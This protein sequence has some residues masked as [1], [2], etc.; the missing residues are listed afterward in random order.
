VGIEIGPGWGWAA[1]ILSEIEEDALALQTRFDLEIG[2]PLN[3]SSRLTGIK[4]LRCPSDD[5]GPNFQTE[6]R[7][8]DVAQANYVGVFGNNEIES[9]PGMGN[10]LFFRN[11]RIRF[12]DILDG[13]SRTMMVGERSSNLSLVT[14]TGAVT[15]ADESAALVLGT[16]DH[17]PNDPHAHPEDFWSRHLSGVNMLFADGSVQT[18]GNSIAPSVWQSLATR[19]GDE[20]ISHI[21]Y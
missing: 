8:V 11:S 20:V 17:S 7:M 5:P 9:N 14:W 16:A 3:A 18:I 2:H 21:D 12:A 6:G 10:G 19:S 1:R 13:Q 4:V 15:G